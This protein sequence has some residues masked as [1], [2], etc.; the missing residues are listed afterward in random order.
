[1]RQTLEESLQSRMN[2]TG[3][4]FWHLDKAQDCFKHKDVIQAIDTVLELYTT[5]KDQEFRHYEEEERG[6]RPYEWT[7][8]EI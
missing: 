6:D 1:M 5:A 7:D 8:E 4:A 3:I 2:D